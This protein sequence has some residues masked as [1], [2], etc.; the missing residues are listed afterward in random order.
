[1]GGGGVRQEE[2]RGEKGLLRRGGAGTAL[3]GEGVW[4]GV[5]GGGEG[6]RWGGGVRQEE[7][8]G[9]RG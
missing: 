9:E 8:R 4:W 1:M 7:M 6:V 5:L 3:W 2:M